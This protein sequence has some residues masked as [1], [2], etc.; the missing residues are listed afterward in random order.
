M[1]PDF[2]K[3]PFLEG[4]LLVGLVLWKEWW[5]QLVLGIGLENG[6]G[7][8]QKNPG[9]ALHKNTIKG[10]ETKKETFIL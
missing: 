2:K 6:W 10:T 7:K 3:C 8:A 5:R 9:A 1:G 4:K